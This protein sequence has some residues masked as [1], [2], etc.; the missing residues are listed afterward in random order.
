MIKEYKLKTGRT[1]FFSPGSAKFWLDIV[2]KSFSVNYY[3]KELI[4]MRLEI[5]GLCNGQ[6]KYCIV[7]G[8]KV[9][10]KDVL[11][12]TNSWD[13][14]FV[15]SWFK[16]LKDIFII[17]GEPM[18]YFN[19]IIFILENFSGTVSFVTNGTLITKEK[20]EKLA[21]YDVMV[22]VSID[23]TKASDNNNRI[24]KD[25][26]FMYDDIVRGLDYLE[27]AG[28]KKGL[29]MVATPNTVYNVSEV[30]I[31]FVD[32]YELK[33]IGYSLPHWTQNEV[34]IVT[35]KQYR[36]AL[37]EIYI[38]RQRIKT[39]VI[40]LNWRLNPLRDGKVKEFACSLHTQQITVLPDKSIVRCSKIDSSPDLN[41]ATNDWLNKNCPTA[42]AKRK[43]EPCESCI[44]L[45]CCGGGCPFDGIK[46][47]N[48]AIDKRE[49]IVTIPLIEKAIQDIIFSLE[50][51]YKHLP[52]GTI[53]TDI[54]KKILK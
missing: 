26:T 21:Q 15:Q 1:L 39:E 11:D 18:L 53:S 35:A 24:Y 45:A 38:H 28:V 9:E 44:A 3:D 47:F 12:I 50:N 52:T 19:D 20:A 48:S 23:G 37:L 54:I 8:N 34:D 33:R 14:F 4:S 6:C 46:R 41:V 17:G 29:F 22:Y 25:G 42:L 27:K 7:Y 16:N 2:P 36:D 49:C 40:Q 31:E 30:L 13:W 10:K 43:I 5:S 51:E 32:K